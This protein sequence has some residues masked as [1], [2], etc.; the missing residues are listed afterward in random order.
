MGLD[1]ALGIVVLIAGIRGWFKGFVR[2]AIP[3]AALVGCVFLA[4]PLRDQV[5]PYAA[6]YLTKI[7]PEVL[8]RLLWW[9]S[10]VLAYVAMA[11]MAFAVVKSFR[12]RTYGDPEPNRADQGAGFLLGGAKGVIV[13]SCL[14]SALQN[15]GPKVYNQA[16]FMEKE[17]RTSQAMTLAET[18]HP[19]E[20]LWNSK[21]VRLFV[22]RVKD[23]GMWGEAEGVRPEDAAPSKKPRASADDEALRTASEKPKTLSLP[24]RLDPE[25]PEFARQLDDAIRRELDRPN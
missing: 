9:A 10:A 5:R 22:G 24:R 2:Q 13:A 3:L 1:V 15:Y 18:Y 14:A 19:A 23:R 7:G 8:D 16:P 25:S 11:G 20:T 21:P 12:K 6:Q 4:D 17:S